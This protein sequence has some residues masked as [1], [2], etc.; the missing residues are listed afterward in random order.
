MSTRQKHQQ[1]QEIESIKHLIKLIKI[2]Y[3]NRKQTNFHLNDFS[4]N[5]FK[6][7]STKQLTIR[8]FSNKHNRFFF[9]EFCNRP[10]KHSNSL[11]SSLKLTNNRKLL[12]LYNNPFTRRCNFSSNNRSYL[13]KTRNTNRNDHF[14]PLKFHRRYFQ[15]YRLANL[16]FSRSLYKI[17]KFFYT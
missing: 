10:P 4:S 14:S 16:Y 13:L 8:L 7:S 9:L 3:S 6:C 15:F 11:I 17:F 5:F 2:L 1:T 12:S